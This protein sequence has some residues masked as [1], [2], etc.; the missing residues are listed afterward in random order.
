[1]RRFRH[2]PFVLFS[3]FP[4][5]A[6]S[7]LISKSLTVSSF[8][9]SFCKACRSSFTSII[10]EL[11][12]LIS[13]LIVFEL[14]GTKGCF[15]L[16]GLTCFCL[17]FSSFGCS[18]SSSADGSGGATPELSLLPTTSSCFL[19][20]GC[21]CVS[22]VLHQHLSPESCHVLSR[23]R[24]PQRRGKTRDF[25]HIFRSTSAPCPL[26][27]RG[28]LTHASM[29][30]V[31]LAGGPRLWVGKLGTMRRALPVYSQ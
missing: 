14:C 28:G 17:G 29:R 19:L 22:L 25:E 4:S 12:G 7:K 9:R 27:D 20:C 6:L 24:P 2:S 1:M 26:Y 13:L 3:S 18:S 10:P 11:F 16:D 21:V 15:A 23:T 5:F 8:N 31:P 30:K